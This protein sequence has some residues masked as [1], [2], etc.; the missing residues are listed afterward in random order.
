MGGGAS[1]FKFT[2]W[3]KVALVQSQFVCGSSTFLCSGIEE[4]MFGLALDEV[5]NGT[6]PPALT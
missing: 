3:L 4:V 1:V 5:E 2:V 6:G